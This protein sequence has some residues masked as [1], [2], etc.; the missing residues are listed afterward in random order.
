MKIINYHALV[1]AGLVLVMVGVMNEMKMAIP[2]P[3]TMMK[4]GVILLAIV[5][6]FLCVWALLS[7]KQPHQDSRAV[8]AFNDATWVSSRFLSSISPLF[9]ATSANLC[10]NS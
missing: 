4:V 2:E 3:N 8:P 5:W 7:L 6:A 1:I 9:L 10:S